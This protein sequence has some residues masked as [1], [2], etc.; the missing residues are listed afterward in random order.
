[1]TISQVKIGLIGKQVEETLPKKK[2]SQRG[3]SAR[4]EKG[5]F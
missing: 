4:N 2:I 5:K 3:D 1:M